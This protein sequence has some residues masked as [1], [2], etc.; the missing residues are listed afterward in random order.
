MF[1]VGRLIT[2]IIRI[3]ANGK[4][5][6]AILYLGKKRSIAQVKIYADVKD[7]VDD[8]IKYQ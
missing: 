5:K 2:I 3:K 7:V 6:E 1:I 8:K 4:I